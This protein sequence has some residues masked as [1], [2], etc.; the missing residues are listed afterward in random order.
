MNSDLI[1]QL[2]SD[3]S[4]TR[5]QYEKKNEEATGQQQE[6]DFLIERVLN[7]RHNE[8]TVNYGTYDMNN[9]YD[10]YKFLT[11]YVQPTHRC[12]NQ[13][14]FD[15]FRQGIKFR[16]QDRCHIATGMIY[17]CTHSAKVHICGNQHCNEANVLKSGEGLCCRLTGNMVGIEYSYAQSRQDVDIRSQPGGFKMPSL[18]NWN[19]DMIDDRLEDFGDRRDVEYILATH[20][21]TLSQDGTKRKIAEQQLARLVKERTKRR[22]YATELVNKLVLSSKY[23]DAM[24]KRIASAEE[25]AE[26]SIKA[27][28]I[29]CLKQRQK[30]DFLMVLK[31]WM[32][33]TKHAY[34]S[35]YYGA[36]LNQ[37]NNSTRIDYYVEC[38]LRIWESVCGVQAVKDEAHC[39]KNCAMGILTHLTEGLMVDIYVTP[40]KGTKPLRYSSLKDSEDKKTA[41]KHSIVLI[42]KH[43]LLAL[44]SVQDIRKRNLTRRKTRGVKRTSLVNQR[45]GRGCKSSAKVS[46]RQREI[47]KDIPTT[48]V[49]K[50]IYE[51]VINSCDTIHELESYCLRNMI[52]L[53]TT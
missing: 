3:I 4:K 22:Q 12:D 9:I 52:K 28:Y 33:K 44:A 45:R 37:L 5:E 20:G 14:N 46:R 51:L 39:F 30:A 2:L 11:T 31:L 19:G 24:R 16:N 13:C 40:S 15:S 6:I 42:D 8:T 10:T 32:M 26:E 50:E 18:V 43:P 41:I 25:A 36:N 53:Q 49:L 29:S 21:S 35:V 17:V 1:N 38:M 47:P 23:E 27:Y 48:K 7:K 34:E